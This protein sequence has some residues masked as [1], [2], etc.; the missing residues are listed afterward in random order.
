MS[1]LVGRTLS[2]Y[3]V[4]G[5]LSR[6]GMGIVYR[7]RDVKLNRD[8]A[9]K[10]LPSELLASPERRR[11]FELEAR[12]AA[13]LSHPNIGVVHEIDEVDGV[14]FIAM[15]LIAGSS[16]SEE[17][18]RE[19]LPLGRALELGIQIADGLSRAHEK[20]IVHRDL[21]PG[22]VMITEDGHAKIID[23]GL[24]KLLAPTEGQSSEL[25]TEAG[26]K[27]EIGAVMG[28]ALYMSPEQARGKKVDARSDIFSFGVVLFELLTG[29]RPFGGP[30]RL[31]VLQAIV[32][33]E[34]PRLGRADATAE[35]QRIVDKCLA[36]DP[37]ER[38]QGMR[39]VVVDLKAERRRLETGSVS[40][41]PST[42]SST[43]AARSP[44]S[45]R[46][47]ALLSAGLVVLLV[48]GVWVLRPAWLG[49]SHP[50][51]APG[52]RPMIA[53]L[54]FESLGGQDGTS[55]AIGITDEITTR[56]AMVSG[57]GVISRRTAVE[58]DR[59]GKTL[60]QVGQDL[61]VGYVLEGSVLFDPS[62]G[63]TG[64]V[65][66][67]PQLIRVADD[68]HVWAGSF[69]RVLDDVFAV[70]SEIA[71]SVA[72]GLDVAIG[73][74]ERRAIAA[75]PTKNLD[76][77]QAYLRGLA[78]YRRSYNTKQGLEQALSAFDQAVSLDPGFATAHAWRS[79]AEID[80]FR[81]YDPNPQR[82][83]AARAAAERAVSL[84]PGSPEG[85]R[86]LGYYYFGGSRDFQA[87]LQE[88]EQASKG[89]PNDPNVLRAIGSIRKRQGRFDECVALLEKAVSL[90]PRDS[91]MASDLASVLEAM[92]RYDEADRYLDIA[93]SLAPDSFL[94]R[95]QRVFALQTRGSLERSRSLLE[96]LPKEKEGPVHGLPIASALSAWIVQ[97]TLERR[98]DEAL[99]RLA[100]AG[101][102]ALTGPTSFP[103]FPGPPAALVKGRLYFLKKDLTRARAAFRE[104]LPPLEEG[105][106]KRAQ[107]PRLHSALAEAYAG[108][109][110]KEDAVREA[111]QAV[112]I[113]PLT[114]DAFNGVGPLVS[115]AIVYT[116]V[117]EHAAAIEVLEDLVS[118]P[119]LPRGYLRNGPTWDP[120]RDDPRFEALARG[121][122]P[123]G[124]G[125]TG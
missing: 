111:R 90:A 92:R 22:N 66:I 124:A 34:T 17:I 9:F 8:V 74:G 32:G 6:G 53:V 93:V 19:P 46:G 21:K 70:Q 114:R 89:L 12:A 117:G 105:V 98:F 121:G 80:L 47:L 118:R 41:A 35:L 28:T 51:P 125:P 45:R 15:E 86:A 99:E 123:G 110:R 40:A 97:E 79:T 23:F 85:H 103:P 10:V 102:E 81:F 4:L 72:S 115:L 77:Y 106:R 73:E 24:A 101:P 96:A 38:Y 108:L 20:G 94:P 39:D 13:G 49:R 5:E 112:E 119:G 104:A 55:F 29:E 54:P 1:S 56:L 27:T 25:E 71:E 122:G 67:T 59:T 63:K 58:Y 107:D 7:A 37:G 26:G 91:E 43:S 68:T 64:R 48:A 2:H 100:A 69:D 113:L 36:K 57:L 120:L 31:D 84:E 14:S 61:G 44:L 75:R 18:A 76:A 52:Q 78:L 95:L 83:E 30:S 62:A 87:A 11:R 50:A 88:L 65:R 16:L 33:A 60:K 3:K 116:M 109:G 42:V 82:L